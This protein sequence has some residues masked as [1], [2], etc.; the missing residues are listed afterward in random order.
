MTAAPGAASGAPPA[1]AACFRCGSFLGEAN[2]VF[3]DLDLCSRCV[4]ESR[5]ASRPPLLQTDAF[6][7]VVIGVAMAVYGTLSV[8]SDRLRWPLEL[9]PHL[10]LAGFVVVFRLLNRGRRAKQ[11]LKLHGLDGAPDPGRFVH[12]HFAPA[13]DPFWS[14]GRGGED[15]LLVEGREGVAFLGARGTRF[16]VPAQAIAGAALE[17]IRMVSTRRPA[18]RLELASGQRLYLAF[19]GDRS[20]RRGPLAEAAA[21]RWTLLAARAREASPPGP[22]ALPSA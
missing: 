13:P 20:R 6:R 17:R 22:V 4:A 5:A 8:F 18:V 14:L 12:A 10:Y 19:A 7:L 15:G 3:R 11:L 16:I 21:A 2:R 1:P 9:L